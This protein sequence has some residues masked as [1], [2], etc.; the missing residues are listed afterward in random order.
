MD[1]I[2]FR[3][4]FGFQEAFAHPV[5]VGIT[6]AVA[7]MLVL[8]AV[9]VWLL[10]VFGLTSPS[11]HDE[12]VKRIRSWAVIAPVLV[13]PI[14]LGAASTILAVAVLSVLCY[15]EF[16]RAT[17]FFRYRALSV[18]VVLGMAALTFATADH[19]YGLFVAV[20]PLTI[21]LL[22]IVGVLRD[23]PK[24][25]T[26][27]VG[28]GIFSFLFFG[29][30]IGMGRRILHC[31]ESGPRRSGWHAGLLAI[32]DAKNFPPVAEQQNNWGGCNE[33]D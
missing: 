31:E 20:P 3:R 1:S 9:L 6:I 32:I 10:H 7:G 2:A 12:L 24:G 13:L 11:L 17:G 19:W 23:E 22:A 21:V 14:L 16:A 28:L 30:C 25:Y 4:L 5:T 33:H 8:A 18:V 27:R 29:V 26:Q 15:R